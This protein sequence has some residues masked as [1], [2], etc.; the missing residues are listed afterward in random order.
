MGSGADLVLAVLGGSLNR[1]YLARITLCSWRCHLLWVC[2][3]HILDSHT[4]TPFWRPLLLKSALSK[5]TIISTVISCPLGDVLPCY[6]PRA[7]H[8]LTL[9]ACV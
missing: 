3:A 4:N 2:H 5:I 6:M 8:W 7:E 1:A 9:L